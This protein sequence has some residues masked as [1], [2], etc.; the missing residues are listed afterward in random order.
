MRSYTN[1]DGDK[2]EVSDKH[3][4]VSLKIYDELSKNSPS[5]RCNWKL[6]KKYMEEEGFYDSES[7]ENYRQM[8]KFER[9]E[10]GTL[11]K[12]ESYADMVSTTKLQS[13]RNAI[14][15]MH[16]ETLET[17]EERRELGR[18]KREINK[19]ILLAEAIENSFSK[20]DF[21]VPRFT[22]IFNN[23]KKTKIMIAGLSDIHYGSEF[24]FEGYGYDTEM[25]KGLVMKYADKLLELAAKE[26]VS[27]I[28]V[29]NLGDNIEGLYMRTSQAYNASRTIAEQ[30][31]E[32]SELII[33]FLT[34]LSQY[35]K[36]T[37]SG[38]GGN[39]DRTNGDK[40]KN[41]WSDNMS[42]VINFAVQT[43]IKYSGSD[44][45]FIESDPFHH[46]A[47]PYKWRFLMVHGDLTPVK[48]PDVLSLQSS[49]Y[50][51]QFDALIYAHVHHFS[52]RE[53]LENRYVASFG[54]IKGTDEY[55][56]KTIQSTTS[57]SQG[58]IVCDE[59]EFEI[60]KINL[61]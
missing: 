11:P 4:D 48:K 50:G 54:S 42:N 3:L 24:N 13:L 9:R 37:Y 52:M 38:I 44:I 6:H 57:R 41:I 30:V 32:V 27:E 53:V 18:L 34:R 28:R 47:N 25:A 33:D 15:E 43:F 40:D 49:L 19:D 26:N 1:Q 20:I 29:V 8:I 36:V 35:V 12:V 2:V 39:H 60:R 31:S 16:S 23:E 7:S 56:L 55:S 22:P 59:D 45:E 58:V 61:E 21:Q 51:H 46:I 10:R 17:R 14:G 5:R